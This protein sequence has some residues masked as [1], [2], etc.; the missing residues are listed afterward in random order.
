M[1][2]NSNLPILEDIEGE[3][4]SSIVIDIDSQNEYKHTP[5]EQLN[6]PLRGILKKYDDNYEHDKLMRSKLIKICSG[7]L[8]IIILAPV[9]FCDLYFGY[10]YNNCSLD[11][12]YNQTISLKLYL[13]VSGF[14]N[15]IVLT[16][17]LIGLVCISN[18]KKIFSDVNL[19]YCAWLI[20]SLLIAGIQLFYILWNILGA[21]VYWGYV[22]QNDNCNIN[23]SSY[24]FISLLLKLLANFIGLLFTNKQ[25][26]NNN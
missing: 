21:I 4:M 7:F 25:N 23:F 12:S 19:A 26:I 17:S 18:Y 6:T 3:R 15:I 22:Y 11:N 20:I 13:L 14:V 1:N 9:I 24:M 16:F 5:D 8:L 10:I 2:T